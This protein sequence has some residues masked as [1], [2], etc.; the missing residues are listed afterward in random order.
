MPDK[1]PPLES[2]LGQ[3]QRL[4]CRRIGR[5]GEIDDGV[6]HVF[7]GPLKLGRLHEH[8]MRIEDVNG[9][10]LCHRCMLP[11]PPDF[12]VTYLHDCSLTAAAHGLNSLFSK[13]AFA[14]AILSRV[15]VYFDTAL[16]DVTYV[17]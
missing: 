7:F 17:L 11:M 2:Q 6:W 16:T 14:I 3:R 8:H 15:H 5:A 13:L 10:L 4:L 1:L 12:F 9:R